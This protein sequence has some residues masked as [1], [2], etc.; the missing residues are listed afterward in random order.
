[1]VPMGDKRYRGLK[2]P[3]RTQL[4]LPEGTLE[5]IEKVSEL[6]GLGKGQYMRRAIL[7]TLSESEQRLRLTQKEDK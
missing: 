7:V 3:E 1:M 4:A 5:R 2:L 6:E